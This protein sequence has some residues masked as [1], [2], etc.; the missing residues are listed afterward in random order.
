MKPTRGDPEVAGAGLTKGWGRAASVPTRASRLRFLVP[1]AALGGALACGDRTRAVDPSG[2]SFDTLANGSVLVTNPIQGVWDRNPAERWR[3]V[4]G[5]RIGSRDDSGPEAF[6]Q[7]GAIVE[8]AGGRV[9]VAD[10]QTNQ[11]QVFDATGG[12]VRTVGRTGEGPGEFERI[13]PAFPGP[14]DQIWVEDIELARFEVFDTA[15]VRIAGHRSPSRLRGGWRHWTPDGR[16]LV[17]DIETS[18]DG[19]D[20]HFLRILRLGPEG[21]LIEAGRMEPPEELTSQGT[22]DPIVFEY[23]EGYRIEQI[24]PFARTTELANGRAGDW[25]L[26]CGLCGARSYD[27][28]RLDQDGDTLL[29]IR[30][31]YEPAA[32]PDSARQE[33]LSS[34]QMYSE[35]ATVTPRLSVDLIP[36]EYPPFEGF[37][38]AADGTLWLR[39]RVADGRVGFDVFD[40][41]GRLLGRPR[42]PAGIE[43]MRVGTVTGRSVYAVDYDEVGVNYVVRLDIEREGETSEQTG[44]YGFGAIVEDSAGVVIVN[45][46]RP[47]PESRLPWEIGG[48]PALAIGSV[49]SGGAD[50]LYAV[51]DA[52]RLP[53]GRIVIG[54]SGSSE[55]RVFN[56]DGSHSATWGG[57]GDGPGEF[58]YLA[59]RDVGLWPGDSIVAA[60]DWGFQLMIFAKDGSHGRD[61]AIE[62]GDAFHNIVDFLP[63]GGTVS[64]G[65]AESLTPV[66][67]GT[68]GLRRQNVEWRI[69]GADGQLVAS[70]GEFPFVEEWVTFTPDGNSVPRHP[71]ARNTVGAAW[72]EFVA[73][74]DQATYEIKAFAADGTL[75]RIVRRDGDLEI[76][77]QADQDSYWEQQYADQPP[78]TRAES[79]RRVRDM[80]L[81]D[82]YPAFSG[83]LSDRLGHL[84]VQEYRSSVWTVFDREGRVQGLVEVPSDLRIFEIGR[85][86]IL[87]R[88]SDVLGVEYVQVWALDRDAG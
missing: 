51:Y 14:D 87:G 4:E 55:L 45:N 23:S 24:A 81:V 38:V 58:A 64:S 29:T 59:P 61:V 2:P 5:L 33:A 67:S 69:L 27:L 17:A 3:L 12:H 60:K 25:W 37:M 86:Y 48:Q 11:I 70:L 53:D 76:P 18:S 54:N 44:P 31:H 9:W 19:A 46:E 39:N 15:G 7:V 34:L 88:S 74:G 65:T 10:M 49:N 50:E 84:W 82:A 83:I 36:R 71:F 22:Q 77:T 57:Q 80:P 79:L 6:G 75:V 40:A 35:G 26:L 32:I 28:I 20:N 8:D 1:V 13:G 62:T 63:G 72:G 52:T 30:R 42:V 66:M 41:D 68:S 43:R 73:I 21:D 78:D 56:P 16:F 85:D 47:P